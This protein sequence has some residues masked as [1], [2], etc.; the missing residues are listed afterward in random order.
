MTKDIA[1]A[2]LMKANHT[3]TKRHKYFCGVVSDEKQKE[4]GCGDYFFES[5]DG[6]NGELYSEL[7]KL[8]WKNAGFNAEYFWKVH[9]NGYIISYTEGDISI[10]AK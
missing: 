9:K 10:R 8:G 6:Q 7:K 3:I 2:D 5:P 1:I 4:I